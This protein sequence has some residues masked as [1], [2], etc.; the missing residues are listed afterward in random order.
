VV[1][2]DRWPVLMAFRRR[3][4]M[5]FAFPAWDLRLPDRTETAPSGARLAHFGGF[6]HGGPPEWRLKVEEETTLSE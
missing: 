4:T 2:S 6:L 1:L 5:G 3:L